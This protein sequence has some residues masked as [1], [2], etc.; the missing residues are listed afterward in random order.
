MHLRFIWFFV[1]QRLSFIDVAVGWFGQGLGA[2][3]G[4][5]YTGKY[6]DKAR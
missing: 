5:A 6:F 1:L 3:C 2:A 4:V